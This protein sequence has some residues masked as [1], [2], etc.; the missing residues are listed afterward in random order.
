[1]QYNHELVND[2]CRFCK[3]HT[4]RKEND[5]LYRRLLAGDDQAGEQ[6][7]VNNMPL[8]VAVVDIFITKHRMYEYL[9]DD[10]TSEGFLAITSAVCSAGDK[11]NIQNITSYLF[12][13]IY[14]ALSTFSDRTGVIGNR[15]SR[16]RKRLA[17]TKITT[18]KDVS[19]CT[20]SK[21]VEPTNMVDLR[22]LVESCCL[23]E[24][25][26]TLIRMREEKYTLRQIASELNLPCT[27]VKRMF[28][29]IRDRFVKKYQDLI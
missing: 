21:T 28:W 11:D 25:D 19:K 13:S 23:S 20:L 27:N 3:K 29:A 5:R 8:V 2:M 10:L 17:Q 16:L 24:S 12:K 22:D 4:D 1:M 14:R 7:V 9:R 18:N 6:L 26:R 15:S